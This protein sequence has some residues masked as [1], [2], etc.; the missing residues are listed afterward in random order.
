MKDG[1]SLTDIHVL[2]SPL[3]M[4]ILVLTGPMKEISE[5]MGVINCHIS[6]THSSN[7]SIAV[8]IAEA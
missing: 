3:G 5:N 8:A 2:Q 1:I 4:P 6:I 7:S